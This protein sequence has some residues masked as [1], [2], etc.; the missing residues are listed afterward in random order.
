MKKTFSIFCIVFGAVLAFRSGRTWD[1]QGATGVILLF[2]GI[3][4]YFK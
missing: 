4:G 1:I 3:F 2:M